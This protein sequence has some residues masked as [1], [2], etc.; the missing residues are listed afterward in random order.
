MKQTELDK[1]GKNKQ[2]RQNCTK[3]GKT[4]AMQQYNALKPNADKNEAKI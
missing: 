2:Q 3:L 1:I 4:T